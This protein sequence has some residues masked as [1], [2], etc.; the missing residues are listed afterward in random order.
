MPVEFDDA[1]RLMQL[2]IERS[3]LSKESDALSKERLS[4]ISTKLMNLK[5]RKDLRTR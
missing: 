5:P 2:E 3:A 4:Q 1:R